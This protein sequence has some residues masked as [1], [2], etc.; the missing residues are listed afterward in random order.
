MHTV[1][2][3]VTMLSILF[4]AVAQAQAPEVYEDKSAALLIEDI[5]KQPWLFEPPETLTPGFSDSAYWIRIT[6]DPSQLP[7]SI[8]FQHLGLADVQLYS[9]GTHRL[10]QHGYLTPLDQRSDPGLLPTFTIR[11]DDYAQGPAYFRVSS[12]LEIA[13]NYEVVSPEQAQANNTAL[14]ILAFGVVTALGA[15]LAYNSIIAVILRSKAHGYYS[16]F[17]SLMLLT[18]LLERNLLHL[19]GVHTDRALAGWIGALALAAG[20]CFLATLFHCKPAWIW[21]SRSVFFIVLM[22]GLLPADMS[23]RLTN[24]ITSPVILLLLLGQI[25]W[26]WRQGSVLAKFI[27]VGWLGFATSGLL[28][29]LAF[30]G[31]VSID[32]SYSYLAGHL[33]EAICFSAAL[34]YRIRS[35]Q[36]IYKDLS[37]LAFTDTLTGMPNRAGLFHTL[38]LDSQNRS[39][40]AYELHLID[41]NHFKSVNDSLSHQAGDALLTAIGSTLNAQTKSSGVAARLGGDEFVALRPWQSAQSCIDF[42][43]A[44][45]KEIE[46]TEIINDDVVLSRSGS[47]GSVLLDKG[48]AL[49]SQ[50]RLADLALAEAKSS[51]PSH[52]VFADAQFYERMKRQGAFITRAEIE[53]GLQNNE[54]AYA[55]QPIYYSDHDGIQV[56]GFEALIRWHRDNEQTLLPAHFCTKFDEI[57]F[58]QKH[59]E[60]RQNM[61]ADVLRAIQPFPDTFISWNFTADQLSQSELIERLIQEFTELQESGGSTNQR[62][63]HQIIIE[64]SEKALNPRIQMDQLI[65]NLSLLR[66][67]GFLI[68]L[69]DFGIENSNIDRLTGLPLDIIKLDISLVQKHRK[70]QQTNL[71]VR[72]IVMMCRS[73][74]LQTIA[75]GIEDELDNIR[76]RAVTVP[77][78]QGFWFSHPISLDQVGQNLANQTPW[79]KSSYNHETL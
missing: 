23:F 41:V 18:I 68:A 12:P 10:A 43:Q 53:H 7:A 28:T 21:I 74:G 6:L 56:K 79:T 25:F 51:A 37:K 67:T 22:H 69:D 19:A 35:N 44:L 13:L 60:I 3:C 1:M 75:E 71:L 26:A 29:L 8:Q 48:Q 57:F 30:S 55:L 45:S 24:Q 62:S 9:R 76:M 70:S 54:F 36:E 15:L 32:F 50:L 34:A 49:N 59:R 72:A 47:I 40:H 78:Q 77:L 2:T 11:P 65:H 31:F 33:F 58:D 46:A 39:N 38:Q 5:R 64:L 73:L 14:S 61:R 66:K 16:V 17:L 27:G 4:A 52:C 20:G 42:A 63:S